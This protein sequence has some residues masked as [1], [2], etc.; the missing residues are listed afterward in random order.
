[1]KKETEI[2]WGS[3]PTVYEKVREELPEIFKQIIN[4]IKSERAKDVLLLSSIISLGSIFYNVSGIYDNKRTY[5]NLFLFIIA[6][7]ASDKSIMTYA[8]TIIEKVHKYILNKSIEEIKTFYSVSKIDC[9]PLAEIPQKKVFII[10][11]NISASKLIHQLNTNNGVG[12]FIE[13][14]ADTIANSFRQD[15]GNYSDNLRK[16]FHNGRLGG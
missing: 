13:E 5:C 1:M 4:P 8:A 14:E 10:P 2:K 11:G 16:V 9:N 7:P 12:I 6:P 3:S 15:W